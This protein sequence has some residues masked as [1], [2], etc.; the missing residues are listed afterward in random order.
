MAMSAPPLLIQTALPQHLGPFVYRVVWGWFLAGRPRT[1][2]T[3]WYRSPQANA[4]EPG[5]LTNSLHLLGLAM[6]FDPWTPALHH[7]YER[8]GLV[9]VPESDHL[10]VQAFPRWRLPFPNSILDL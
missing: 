6:D 2:I 3:S 9:S 5:A 8:L 4:A 1:A 7:S 10:H